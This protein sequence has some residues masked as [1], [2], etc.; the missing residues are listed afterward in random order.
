MPHHQTETGFPFV[1]SAPCNLL[2]TA[3]AVLLVAVLAG[4]ATAP[5]PATTSLIPVDQVRLARS[6][7]LEFVYAEK[8]LSAI[9]YRKTLVNSN[10]LTP[11]LQCSTSSLISRNS[12]VLGAWVWRS[13]LLLSNPIAAHRFLKRAAQNGIGNL[14]MQIQPDLGSFPGFINKAKRLHIKVYALTGSPDD[15][16]NYGPALRSIDQV[17]AFN[18]SHKGQFSGIQFDV[19][20]YLLKRYQTDKRRILKRY[21]GLLQAIRARSFGKIRVSVVVPFWFDQETVEHRNLMGIVASDTDSLAIM[22]YRTHI[23]QLLA[24]SNDGLCYAQ[25]YGKPAL[26]GIELRRIPSEIHYFLAVPQLSRYI[27]RSDGHTFLRKDPRDF[28]H[29]ARKYTVHGSN[30]SFYPHVHAAFLYTQSPIPYR[31][32]AGWIMDGLGQTWIR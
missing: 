18:Q 5:T 1:T 15:V 3:A 23:D 16:D 27:R 21:V 4:C 26:L 20:P 14:Y 31:S 12:S 11:H 30:I 2:R 25:M 24:V 10:K 28:I 19:E 17:L 8:R 29:F 22:S 7:Y 6:R 32:F 13:T 9:D